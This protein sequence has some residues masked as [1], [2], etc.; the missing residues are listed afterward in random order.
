MLRSMPLIALF[1]IAAG[2]CVLDVPELIDPA[3]TTGGGGSTDLG[4]GGAGAHGGAAQCPA[5]SADCD[6]NGTCETDLTSDSANC[7]ICGRECVLTTCEQSE[8]LRIALTE[9]EDNPHLV[10]SDEQYVYVT[11]GGASTGAG[12]VQRVHRLLD[13]PVFD[14]VTQ[15]QKPRGIALYDDA[16]GKRWVYWSDGAD[17]SVHR[18]PAD[19]QT[20]SDASEPG[21]GLDEIVCD[22]PGPT[23]FGSGYAEAGLAVDAGRVYWTFQAADLVLAASAEPGGAVDEL[24]N[25]ARVYP[26]QIAILGEYVYITGGSPG[27]Y[28]AKKDGT[29]PIELIVSQPEKQGIHYGW[30]IVVHDGVV[31]WREGGYNSPQEGDLGRIVRYDPE[32]DGLEAHALLDARGSRG[33]ATDGESLFWTDGE[34]QGLILSARLSGDGERVLHDQQALPTGIAADQ[35]GPFV[36]WTTRVPAGGL[37][38]GVK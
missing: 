26:R 36:Y 8:C 9:N 23:F 4:G 35:D 6:E 19:A 3:L 13:T 38:R 17:G 5:G 21:T 22:G 12:K 11:I 25:Q 15:A 7:S 31:Y 30:G 29:G 24:A 1:G 20:T 27:I 10:T 37:Y 16:R 14:L 2:A 34:L 32:V 18:V 33:I 28:R